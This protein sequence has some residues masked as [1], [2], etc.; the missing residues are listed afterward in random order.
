MKKQEVTFQGEPFEKKYLIGKD[1]SY[2]CP[3]LYL[4]F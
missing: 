2:F 1:K 4:D 3:D